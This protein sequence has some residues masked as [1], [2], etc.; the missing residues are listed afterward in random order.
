MQSPR[1]NN[2]AR[3]LLTFTINELTAALMLVRDEN[4]QGYHEDPAAFTLHE[5]GGAL[6]LISD[7]N[8]I[9]T[10]HKGHGSEELPSPATEECPACVF[11]RTPA[12]IAIFVGQQLHQAASRQART[13]VLSHRHLQQ[14]AK[15]RRREGAD[16]V[17]VVVQCTCR[18]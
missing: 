16:L 5:L 8:E 17:T 4:N 10:A 1:T 6:T 18:D 12:T 9:F 11:L 15:L 3:R 2:T 14:K 7:Q 13:L